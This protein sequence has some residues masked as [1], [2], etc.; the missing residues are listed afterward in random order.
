MVAIS[1]FS[2]VQAEFPSRRSIEGGV[3]TEPMEGSFRRPTNQ[4]DA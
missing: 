2:K 3:A 1:I 4:T